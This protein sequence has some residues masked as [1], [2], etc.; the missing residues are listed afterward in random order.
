MAIASRQRGIGE[1][2]RREM[3]DNVAATLP[4]R[5]VGQPADIA[6]AVLFLAA[7]PF[8]TG[9]TVLVDGGGAIA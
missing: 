5:A 6:N 2:K 9:S 1:S 8:T 3:F 4:A 7:N